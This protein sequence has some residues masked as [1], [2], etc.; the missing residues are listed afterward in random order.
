MEQMKIFMG[1]S[2]YADDDEI[3]FSYTP[4]CVREYNISISQRWIIENE[5]WSHVRVVKLN[6]R[7]PIILRPPFDPGRWW[8]VL[9]RHAAFH[10]AERIW[11]AKG[12][13]ICSFSTTFYILH[14][15]PLDLWKCKQWEKCSRP[16][17]RLFT[18][19]VDSET[20]RAFCSIHHERRSCE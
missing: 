20:I 15:F 13:V 7:A 16:G 1:F 8:F 18:L 11:K 5:S 17:W 9:E 2:S 10:R 19:L 14:L 12:F 4:D 6:Q 3:N